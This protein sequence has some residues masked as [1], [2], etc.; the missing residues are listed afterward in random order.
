M[1]MIHKKAAI[2]KSFS[3][4]GVKNGSSPPQSTDNRFGVA[5]ELFV[6]K[7]LK[8]A[9]EK[10]YEAAKAAAEEQGVIDKEAAV[11]G[12]EVN[13][14]QSELFDIGLKK[15]AGSLSL[16]KTMLGNYLKRHHNFSEHDVNKALVNGSKPRAGAVNINISLK[17]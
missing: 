16:D 12:V 7:E 14:Y 3:A 2:Q 15:S 8:S 6:A 1:E 17:G 5:Y 10:R 13:T 9:A 4:I 11:E